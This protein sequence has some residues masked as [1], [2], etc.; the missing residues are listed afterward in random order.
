MVVQLKRER[1]AAS[2]MMTAGEGQRREAELRTGGGKCRRVQL[3]GKVFELMGRSEKGETE[4]KEWAG[5]WKVL[6][7]TRSE[8]YGGAL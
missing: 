7:D 6:V 5:D 4:W 8:M 1:E 2:Q 3:G